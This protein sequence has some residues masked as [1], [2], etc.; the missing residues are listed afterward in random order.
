MNK[1]IRLLAFSALLLIP[2]GAQSVFG[3]ESSLTAVS[4]AFCDGVITTPPTM[5]VHEIGTAPGFTVLSD[6]L[7]TSSPR[8]LIDEILC[9]V[10]STSSDFREVTVSISNDQPG[11][12]AW[13][14]L[15]FVA[16]RTYA[17]GPAGTNAFTNIDWLVTGPNGG[18]V[19][20]FKIDD[21]GLHR[22]LLAGDNNNNLVFDVGETWIFRVQD[23]RYC[24]FP[25]GCDTALGPHVLG[26]QGWPG[27]SLTDG[28][29]A[30][31]IA[32]PFMAPPPDETMVWIEKSHDNSIPDGNFDFDITGTVSDSCTIP[33]SNGMGS[34]HFEGPNALPP[35]TYTVTEVNDENLI[36]ADCGQGTGNTFTVAAGE[37]VTCRFVNMAEPEP[38][39]MPDAIGGSIIPVETTSLLVAGAQS[40]SWMIP[41]ILSGI[42]IGLFVATRKTEN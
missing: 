17:P 22:P 36:A 1:V 33:T 42:G 21:V 12:Q 27:P 26:S 24:Q 13:T 20:A 14:D 31:I 5:N 29:T 30:S 28:S 39:P 38:M 15:W 40:N 8:F 25:S 7:I 37:M 4:P 35:G 32:V 3:L 18:P 19:P 41:L 34:C 23:W 9:N 6:E 2:V 10:P 11:A 16:D